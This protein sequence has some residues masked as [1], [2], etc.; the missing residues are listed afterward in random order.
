MKIA[1]LCILLLA[2]CGQRNQEPYFVG[3]PPPPLHTP[4]SL[5]EAQH[6]GVRLNTDVWTVMALWE[7]S[8]HR[9]E[10]F[11]VVWRDGYGAGHSSTTTFWPLVRLRAVSWA[12]YWGYFHHT[13]WYWDAWPD[14][15]YSVF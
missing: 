15:G 1:L 6:W 4:L 2:A 14:Y 9:E 5:T 13:E 11:L 12:E 3:P 7:L 8:G 10:Q